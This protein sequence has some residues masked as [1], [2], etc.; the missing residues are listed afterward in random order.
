[1]LATIYTVFTFISTDSG[2]GALSSLEND[3]R[4]W[5]D[6]H[7]LQ[8][9]AML[10]NLRDLSCTI[11]GSAGVLGPTPRGQ[12]DSVW[13]LT[14]GL[15]LFN[16]L[17]QALRLAKTL[18]PKAATNPREQMAFRACM[19]FSMTHIDGR[20]DGTSQNRKP[21]SRGFLLQQTCFIC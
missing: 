21:L 20:L 1:M 18:S 7:R 17:N 3:F 12:S 4:R 13:Y 16:V 14:R 5:E 8:E 2:L 15:S 11:W 6:V 19:F 10:S 9:H